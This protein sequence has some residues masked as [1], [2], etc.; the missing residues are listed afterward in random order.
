MKAYGGVD[1]EIHIFLTSALAGVEGS[2][3]RPRHCTPEEIVPST[4]WIGGWVGPRTSMEVVVDITFFSYWES[5]SGRP[6]R[7][8]MYLVSEEMI[9]IPI[10]KFV[11]WI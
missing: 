5:N 10:L 8:P 9:F 4:P 6:Y 2:A 11:C 3:S 1:V 7:V